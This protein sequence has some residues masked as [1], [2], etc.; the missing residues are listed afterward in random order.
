VIC[1]PVGCGVYSSLS[2]DPASRE[3]A[4]F[5]FRSSWIDVH[6]SSSLLP[7]AC[8]CVPVLVSAAK[9]LFKSSDFCV[10]FCVNHCREMLV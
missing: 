3:L 5:L 1:S 2:L 9:F 8:V 6:G 4:A 10:D 7:L